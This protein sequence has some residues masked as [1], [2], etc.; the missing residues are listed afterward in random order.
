MPLAVSEISEI[1]NVLLMPGHGTRVQYSLGSIKCEHNL[2]VFQ[3]SSQ[4][5]V[6]WRIQGSCPGGPP[7]PL[8]FRRK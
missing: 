1:Q 6:Q 4:C 3:V 5:T 2:M 7:P 8:I